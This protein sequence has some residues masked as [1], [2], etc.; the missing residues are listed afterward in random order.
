MPYLRWDAGAQ[1]LV[2]EQGESPCQLER[3][4]T[5]HTERSS[6]S[7]SRRRRSLLRFHSLTKLQQ[8]DASQGKSIPFLWTVGQS[9]ARGTVESLANRVIS[10]HL[11]TCEADS[12]ATDA[13]ALL[14]DQAAGKDVV[15]DTI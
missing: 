7:S 12:E 2:P 6:R 13:T 10:Q 5:D 9:D 8:E 11:A 1:Q 4:R 3:S 14:P 15:D